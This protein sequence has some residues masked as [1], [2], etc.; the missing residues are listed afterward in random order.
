MAP[1]ASTRSSTSR[2]KRRSIS[3]TNRPFRP[4]GVGRVRRPSSRTSRKPLV[5]IRPTCAILRSS[6]ALVVVVVPWTIASSP[7]ASTPAAASAARTP[8]AWF[9]EVVGTLAICTWP[10]ASSTT[11]RSVKVPPTSI[12]ATRLIRRAAKA[13]LVDGDDVRLDPGVDGAGPEAR[14]DGLR[15][16]VGGGIEL[17]RVARLDLVAQRRAEAVRHRRRA[18]RRRATARGDR[19]RSRHGTE[20]ALLQVLRD[21]REIVVPV[22]N[23]SQEQRRI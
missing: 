9:S 21:R 23:A 2:R 12:P 15:R 1:S 17:R 18:R 8:K 5:V 22:R 6:I 4:Y 3:G 11:T 19:V 10:V 14:G 20:T 16:R 13:S 7:A